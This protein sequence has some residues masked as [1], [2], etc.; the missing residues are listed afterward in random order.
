MVAR[1]YRTEHHEEIVTPSVHE[2]LCT[3]VE[4]YDEPFADNSAI[5]TLY[6]AR[7]TRKYV[8][9][10]LSG[11]GADEL[12][13]GYRR[14][15]FSVAEERARNLMPGWLRRSAIRKA[16]EYY[17]KFDYLPR[18]LRAKT[19]LL[20]LAQDL[21]EAYA[22]A[23]SGFRFGLLNE[24]LAPEV[25]GELDGYSPVENF[26]SRFAKYRHLPPLG[27]LQAVDLE[28]YLPGDILVKV[29]R[30]SMAYSLEARCPWLDYRLGELALRLPPAFKL[31]RGVGKYVF[32]EMVKPLIP[33]EIVTRPK[34]GFVAPAGE[35]FRSSLKKTFEA[36]VFRA[37]LARYVSLEAVRRIWRMHQAGRRD[38]GREL[39]GLLML[40]CWDDRHAGPRPGG[41][42]EEALS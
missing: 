27:Q 1:R 23:M 40:A 32:K 6:L 22:A 4:H 5:P 2:T 12:F 17:P 26:A 16:G 37:D 25:R 31:H 36:L 30:A 18:I 3:L 14:Y 10:A 9:V 20:G 29:D 8:T 35:W 28:T 19:T 34:M 33:R 7:M 24:V 39:W 21:G 15:R 42:L 38:F 11:D 41:A 13:G